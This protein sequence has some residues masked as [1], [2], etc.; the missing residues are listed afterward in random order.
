MQAFALIGV[1][2]HH[3]QEYQFR[4]GSTYQQ[5]YEIPFFILA[6]DINE[7]IVQR[8]NLSAYRFMDF[9]ANWIGVTT[10]LTHEGYDI[11]T[12]PHDSDVQVYNFSKLVRYDGLES[13]AALH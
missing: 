11:R 6:S 12:A 8:K 7:R 3:V 5:N 1:R 2:T 4:H 13:Q 9:F 10:P